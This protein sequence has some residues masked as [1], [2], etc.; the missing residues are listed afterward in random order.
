[1]LL[2][3]LDVSNIPLATF[4]NLDKEDAIDPARK[5]HVQDDGTILAVVAT[6]TSS[7]ESLMTFVRIL[8]RENPHLRSIPVIISNRDN[9]QGRNANTN[10]H[11]KS[12]ATNNSQ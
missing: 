9:V 10:N 12:M 8:E 1:M 4:G 7:Q 6:G 2:Y 3:L 11:E 5:L